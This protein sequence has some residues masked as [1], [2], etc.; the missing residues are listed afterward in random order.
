MIHPK[1][2]GRD[3]RPVRSLLM[4]PITRNLGPQPLDQI[5][6]E[7]GLDNAALVEASGGRLTFKQVGKARRGRWLT[8]RIRLRV[9]DALAR[10]LPRKPEWKT[11]E[12]FD[13]PDADRAPQA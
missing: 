9:R 11:A 12:L 3:S 13:Y 2:A 8:L 10:V 7:A 1:I 5:M 4:K 6:T